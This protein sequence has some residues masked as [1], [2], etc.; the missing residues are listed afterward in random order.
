[1]EEYIGTIKL[2]GGHFVPV[3]YM[4]CNGQLLPVNQYEALFAIIGTKFGGDGM[5]TFAL[6]KL[7]TP[8]ESMKYLICVVGIFPSPN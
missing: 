2:F 3:G 7:T 4:E 6:P 8:S 1:M 5:S